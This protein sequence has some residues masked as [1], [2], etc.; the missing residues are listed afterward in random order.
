MSDELPPAHAG[1]GVA[2]GRRSSSP[3]TRAWYHRSR[4]QA[5]PHRFPPYLPRE[6][7]NRK[8]GHYPRRGGRP[9]A[10]FR[11][12]VLLSAERRPLL[13]YCTV[14]PAAWVKGCDTGSR[15]PRL[16]AVTQHEKPLFGSGDPKSPTSLDSGSLPAVFRSA[17]LGRRRP[18]LRDRIPRNYGSGPAKNH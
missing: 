3:E 7:P 6:P 12:D 10:R 18:T 15:T 11:R 9:P 17:A 13:L 5:G 4:R 16:K 2:R 1:P 8:A 14:G